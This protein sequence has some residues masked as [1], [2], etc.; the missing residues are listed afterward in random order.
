VIQ[1]QVSVDELWRTQKVR[2]GGIHWIL[3]VGDKETIDMDGGGA[4]FSRGRAQC[5]KTG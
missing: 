4:A 2:G 1:P 5:I 3:R